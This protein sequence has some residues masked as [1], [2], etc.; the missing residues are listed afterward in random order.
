[1]DF[2]DNILYVK[3]VFVPYAFLYILLCFSQVYSYVN[4]PKYHEFSS[5]F[6]A[7]SIQMQN[8]SKCSKTIMKK[9]GTLNTHP[10]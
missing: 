6:P 9:V 4:I 7:V 5:F 10:P 8:S 2:C 1:M 3:F